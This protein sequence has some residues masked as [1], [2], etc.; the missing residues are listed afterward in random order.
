MNMIGMIFA[1]AMIHHSAP[2]HQAAMPVEV[3]V[4]SKPPARILALL[5]IGEGC[6]IITYNQAYLGPIAGMP[7]LVSIG[8]EHVDPENCGS[9]MP[10]AK[11]VAF[12]FQRPHALQLESKGAT[13]AVMIQAIEGLKIIGNQIEVRMLVF[14]PNDPACCAHTIEDMDFRIQGGR[15]IRVR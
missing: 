10:Y 11:I 5:K 8:I 4:T 6:N 12:A 13:G 1:A 14:G 2:I 3:S 9:N 7:G 15:L